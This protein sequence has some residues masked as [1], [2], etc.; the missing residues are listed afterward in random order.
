[1]VLDL[2]DGL[3]TQNQFNSKTQQQF[4]NSTNYLYLEKCCTVKCN[5][6]NTYSEHYI[7][8]KNQ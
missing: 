4:E 5:I 7:F 1:M 6:N 8:I 3:S 2:D